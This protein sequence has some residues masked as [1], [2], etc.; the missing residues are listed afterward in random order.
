M[1]SNSY[2]SEF[3]LRK[4]GQHFSNYS[5]IQK[6]SELSDG[7]GGQACLEHCPKFFRFL[8]FTLPLVLPNVLEYSDQVKQ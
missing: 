1:F 5:D 6:K 3:D 8:N 4:V 7:E 2:M